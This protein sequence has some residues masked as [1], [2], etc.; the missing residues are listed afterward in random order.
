M[1][2]IIL[3]CLLSGASAGCIG[4]I[5]NMMSVYTAARPAESQPQFPQHGKELWSCFLSRP[6]MWVG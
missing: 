1:N 6:D 2:K 5:K 3:L 4:K